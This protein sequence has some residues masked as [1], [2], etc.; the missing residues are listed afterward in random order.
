MSLQVRGFTV[1]VATRYDDVPAGCARYVSV[2][3]SVPGAA[4][5]WDHHVTGERINLDAMPARFDLS[6]F[7]GIGTTLA[8]MDAVASVVA[9]LHGGKAALPAQAR[10]VLEAASCW[11]DHL[12][13]HPAHDAETNRLGRGLLDVVGERLAGPPDRASWRF[14]DACRLVDDAVRAGGPLPYADRF[15][16]RVERARKLFTEGRARREGAVLVVD[17]RG[18]ASIDPAAV[19]SLDDATVAVWVDDHKAGG[20]RY[21]VGLNPNARLPV[22]DVRPALTALAAAEFARGAPTLAPTPGT[23]SENWG[24][25]QAV[26]GSPWNY[27]SRLKPDEVVGLVRAALGV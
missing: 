21:T 11:C 15:A 4:L 25:R 14:A 22:D 10:G 19:L 3:G 26:F 24:G 17:R 27:G 1:F 9:A 18:W 6:G 7:D 12:G 23:A 16:E 20:P 2:D 5:V 13:P 8:D